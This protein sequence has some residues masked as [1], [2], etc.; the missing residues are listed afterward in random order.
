VATRYHQRPSSLIGL[1]P[2]D[3]LA[4]DFDVAVMVAAGARDAEDEAV[5]REASEAGGAT[6]IRA[7]EDA[8]AK[9]GITF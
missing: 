9:G 5:A 2:A 1:R 8:P 7:Q 6:V 4:L 3:P